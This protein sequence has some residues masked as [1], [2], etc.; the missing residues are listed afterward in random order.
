MFN[1]QANIDVEEAI[2]L[3]IRD[4]LPTVS[5]GKYNARIAAPCEFCKQRHDVMNDHCE[6]EFM[7][8]DANKPE[9][10]SKILLEN[11]IN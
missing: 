1:E 6:L 2:L 4:N 9:I 11:V 7:G 5:S 8:L 10:A 3:Q